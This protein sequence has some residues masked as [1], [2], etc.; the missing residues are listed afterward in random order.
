MFQLYNVVQSI[1]IAKRSRN[2][3]FVN[4]GE[5]L[6]L[7]VTYEYSGIGGVGVQWRNKN[8]KVLIERYR[9]GGAD[10]VIDSRASFAGNATLVLTNTTLY[11][12][13]TYRIRVD[14]QDSDAKT[15]TFEV[16]IRGRYMDDLSLF[17]TKSIHRRLE[18]TPS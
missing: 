18:K 13:G 3:A 8:G 14:P 15:E 10:D 11:D 9:I 5:T 17:Q 7:N 16:I 12:N 4:L 1:K 2:A 6:V